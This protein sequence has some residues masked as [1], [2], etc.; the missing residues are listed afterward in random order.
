MEAYGEVF[1]EDRGRDYFNH[2]YWYAVP[3]ISPEDDVEL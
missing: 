2:E 3:G 1:Y